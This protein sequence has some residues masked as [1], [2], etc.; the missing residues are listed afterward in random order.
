MDGM[1]TLILGVFRCPLLSKRSA[2]SANCLSPE[3]EFLR[4][5]RSEI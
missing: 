4:L 5:Q 1:L 3:G 2:R